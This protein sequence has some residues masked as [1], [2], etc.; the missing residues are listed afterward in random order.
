MT[1][2]KNSKPL[3]PQHIVVFPDGNRRWARERNL[4]VA[5]GYKEGYRNFQ[6]FLVHCK[7]RGVKVLTI[8]GFSTENWSR[9]QEEVAFLMQFFIEAVSNTESIQ[10]L[11]KEGVRV[12]IIGQKDRL[13]PVLREKMARMEETLKD[14]K[15][16]HLN[17]A[18]S[19]GGRWDIVQA[20][21]KLI[22]E[23]ASPEQVTEEKF[24]QYLSTAGLPDPDLIIR[25]GGEKRL[26]NFV[27]WQA[28]YAELYFSPKYWPDFNEAELDEALEEFARRQRRFGK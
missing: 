15:N 24:G 10:Q 23:G 14:E 16:F 7:K 6:R 28:A 17:L 2:N 12:W 8:F 20:A 3:I 1:E 4:S 18:V 19:Y 13:T 22:K 26:S 25:A 27:L 5:E 21:Q 11:K 9:P